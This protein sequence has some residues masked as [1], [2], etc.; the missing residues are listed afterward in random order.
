MPTNRK[1]DRYAATTTVSSERSRVEIERTLYRYGARQFVYGRDDD[2]RLAVIEFVTENRRIRLVLPVPDPADREFTQT[3]H[4]PPQRR[5]VSAAS[6]AYDQ[7]VR[8]RWRA[9]L[10]IIKAKLEAVAAGV[11]TFENEFLPYTV[12]PDGRTVGEAVYAAIDQAYATGQ[13][14]QL[15]PGVTDQA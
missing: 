1:T 8:Q 14:P 13:V 15:L 4:Q 3:R 11:M 5:S 9:L 10:L 12:L 6:A 7:A 2:R